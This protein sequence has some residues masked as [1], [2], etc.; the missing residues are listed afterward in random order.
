MLFLRL[1]DTNPLRAA[2]E[3]TGERPVDHLVVSALERRQPLPALAPRDVVVT[4][5][6]RLELAE[7]IEAVEAITS[8][9]RQSNLHADPRLPREQTR[10]LYAAW[11]RNDVTGRAVRTFLARSERRV[12]GY[13]T[14]IETHEGLALD[15]VAVQDDQQGRGVGSAM[16]ASTLAWATET[17]M[18][19]VGTQQ[20]N[21]ALALYGR[22]GF[23]P[24]EIHVMY[25]LWL[26]E[27]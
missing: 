19:T 6:D 21:R 12:V 16:L 15:L 22:F 18:V 11:A 2:V 5:H 14:V 10:A 4:Q 9:I 23:V 20:T 13:I 3:G 27:T 1:N 26:T 25:H 17:T 24:R 8:T 7:E